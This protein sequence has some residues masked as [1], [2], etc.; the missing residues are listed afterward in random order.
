[1]GILMDD[2]ASGRNAI[3]LPVGMKKFDWD[4]KIRDLLPDDW[5]LADEWAT[6]KL[7]VRDI[8]T[9]VSGLPRCV[10][11]LLLRC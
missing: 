6:A 10:Y 7:N 9:H 3:P 5:E 8:L 11:G 4:T 1:M 2:F